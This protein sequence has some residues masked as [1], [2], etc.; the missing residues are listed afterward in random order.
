[1]DARSEARYDVEHDRSFQPACDVPN[2]TWC[3]SLLRGVPRECDEAVTSQLHSHDYIKGLTDLTVHLR[4]DRTPETDCSPI[5]G[6]ADQEAQFSSHLFVDSPDR[7][8]CGQKTLML[9][10]VLKFSNQ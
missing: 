10:F 4:S 2:N 8:L 6:F 1:M 5:S 9:S 7:L 3:H